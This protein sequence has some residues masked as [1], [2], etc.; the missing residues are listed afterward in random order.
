M[1]ITPSAPS[2]DGSHQPV[3]F[4]RIS[5]P[6]STCGTGTVSKYEAYHVPSGA[7]PGRNGP[8]YTAT[9]SMRS[10]G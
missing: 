6:Y 7:K 5:S 3:P 8:S 4:G 10:A 9:G 1:A 2:P